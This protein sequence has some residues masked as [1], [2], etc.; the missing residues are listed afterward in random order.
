MSLGWTSYLISL[1]EP[2]H[3]VWNADGTAVAVASHH[4]VGVLY[5]AAR[6]FVEFDRKFRSIATLAWTSNG[7]VVV[8]EDRHRTVLLAENGDVLA[9][10]PVAGALAVTRPGT[11][12]EPV[13]LVVTDERLHVL[14]CSD[15]QSLR[16]WP[17]G[18]H[19]IC[20]HGRIATIA[21]DQWSSLDWT[22]GELVKRLDL[23]ETVH[24]LTL[25]PDGRFFAAAT[26]QH[27][28]WFGRVDTL[29]SWDEESL[30][31]IS[32]AGSLA[33]SAL[34]L[35]ANSVLLDERCSPLGVLRTGGSSLSYHTQAIAPDGHRL[36]CTAESR[37]HIIDLA[38]LAE[39][40]RQLPGAVSDIRALTV[41]DVGGPDGSSER[42]LFAGTESGRVFVWNTRS[43]QLATVLECSTGS[44]SALA[45]SRD[46]RRLYV[47]AYEGV[48]VWDWA[49]RRRVAVWC[50]EDLTHIDTLKCRRG[51]LLAVGSSRAALLTETGAVRAGYGPWKQ[52]DRDWDIS[53]RG[54][55]LHPSESIVAIARDD[56]PALLLSDSGEERG[57]MPAARHVEFH[58]DGRYIATSDS[59]EA[60]LR[61]YPL[62]D[63]ATATEYPFESATSL[64]D[65]FLWG[66]GSSAGR[67]SLPAAGA[68]RTAND[69]GDQHSWASRFHDG[70]R[71]IASTPGASVFHGSG[72][73]RWIG[74]RDITDGRLLAVLPAG[75]GS[76]I[77]A[78]AFHPSGDWLAAGERGG[79]VHIWRLAPLP[80]RVAFIDGSGLQPEGAVFAPD[81]L[82]DIE[83]LAFPGALVVAA[84]QLLHYTEP[85]AGTDLSLVRPT[86]VEIAAQE[87]TPDGRFALVGHGHSWSNLEVARTDDGQI[88]ASFEGLP[89]RDRWLSLSDDGELLLLASCPGDGTEL[90]LWSVLSNE[91]IAT[92]YIDRHI[93]ETRFTPDGTVVLWL[94][95]YDVPGQQAGLLARWDPSAETITRW[96]EPPVQVTETSDVH[97]GAGRALFWDSDGAWIVDLATAGVAPRLLPPHREAGIA[98]GALSPDGRYAV[99]ADDAGEMR[100]WDAATGAWLA[101]LGNT[102]DGSF[103]RRTS[104]GLDFFP[105]RYVAQSRQGAE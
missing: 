83:A 12:D 98:H 58:A 38:T 10:C 11:R 94:Q 15:L 92:M 32:T 21:G 19:A 52:P 65:G 91:R 7:L 5:L 30:T 3:A 93:R 53:L 99:T 54:G 75:G 16:E 61:Q 60:H 77:T 80:E 102:G 47:G 59:S 88:L 100:L 55:D 37:V 66:D 50:A 34:G 78:L 103:W 72:R 18:G 13:A 45:T 48:H 41:T 57:Q 105:S 31:R 40:S 14:S 74:E 76:D 56:M 71:C 17:V 20:A 97:F 49:K 23:P 84:N 51:L 63:E 44:I 1:R 68:E 70:M 28:T 79:R 96:T 95:R 101:S 85:L 9:E 36:A 22:T 2:E 25:S 89:G 29:A 73:S 69:S 82:G 6:R 67:L 27:N 90:S 64:A 43:R 81:A 26:Y 104:A 39:R 8:D 4:S 87:L 33:Y 46:G 24:T 42:I 86:V 62:T 35:I